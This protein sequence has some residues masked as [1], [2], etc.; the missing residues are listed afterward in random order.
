MRM[1]WLS[2]HGVW[3]IDSLMLAFFALGSFVGIW[4]ALPMLNVILDE[5]YFVGGVLRAIEAKSIL[6]LATDVPY[7]TI[8]FYLN[9]A[10]QIPFLI[11]LLAWK[12]F[13]IVSLKTYLVLHPETAYLVPRLLSAIV[14]SVVALAYDRFLRSEG[15]SLVQRFAVLS[16]IFSTIIATVTLHTGKVWVISTVLAGASAL[17][18][19]IA[20]RNY[21]L[22]RPEPM[23][24]PAFWSIVL[25]FT[26]LANFPLVGIFLI[27]VPLFLYVFRN[28]AVRLR[29]TGK[30]I[31]AGIL[32]LFAVLAA[33]WSN[34]YSLVI[35]IFTNFHP[36]LNGGM[37][38][39][40]VPPFSTSLVFHFEQALV[41]FPLVIAVIIIAV[42][43]RAIQNKLLF[44]L[45][46]MYAGLYFL[47]IVAV[48]TW[49][50]DT[51]GQLHYLFPLAFFFSGMIASVAYENMRHSL[52]GFCVLQTFVFFYVLYLLSVPTTFNQADTFIERNFRSEHA[53]ILNDVVELSL[54]LNKETALL[55]RDEHCGSKCLYLRTSA[56]ESD[57]I[58]VVVTSQSKIGEVDVAQYSRV[59]L[60]TDRTSA[61]TC[62]SE[63]IKT[64]QSGS[65]DEEY[66][67]V[68]RNFGHYF[69]P[70]FWRLSR[71]GKNLVLFEVPKQCAARL[72]TVK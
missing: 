5:Q 7:G 26:A 43:T 23:Y 11:T 71:L 46:L 2:R 54:P 39:Q 18:T 44:R 49:F 48:A 21:S 28:D 33:N 14:A 6:P 38:T 17:C 19:Y 30:A 55:Q 32:I 15:L 61:E 34:I 40:V 24:G 4:H 56:P 66:V 69:L 63:P 58:P 9:Y 70:D 60:I 45:S 25:V 3:K 36:I 65:S 67:S 51:G 62:I 68:E 59:L 31:L 13:S 42:G 22:G 64:F 41:A 20:L 37:S 27:N 57:F 10:L 72:L 53:L 29:A 35:H 8:T 47:T 50:D 12:G 16:V 52:W 1:S